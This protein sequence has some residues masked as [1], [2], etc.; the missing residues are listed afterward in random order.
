[1]ALI[2]PGYTA[3]DER[4]R[5]FYRSSIGNN[6]GYTIYEQGINGLDPYGPSK[7]FFKEIHPLDDKQNEIMKG[8]TLTFPNFFLDY[9]S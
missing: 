8:P 9:Y 3:S 2:A 4:I 1:M 6:K 7:L 5:D